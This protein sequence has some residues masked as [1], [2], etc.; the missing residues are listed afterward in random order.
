[1]NAANANL[2]STLTRRGLLRRTATGLLAAATL[3]LFGLATGCGGGGND[4]ATTRIVAGPT[5]AVDGGVTSSW[6]K[7]DASNQVIEAGLTLPLAAI[8]TPSE[9][10]HRSATRHAGTRHETGPAGS[11]LTLDF[12]EVVQQTA[13]LNHF[14]LHWNPNGHEP[15]RYAAPHFDFHFYGVPMTEVAQVTA[16]DPVAPDPSRVPAGY[17]YAGREACV[18]QMGVHAVD[19]AEFAPD[20]APFR[21]SMILGY[22][23]GKMTFVEPMITRAALLEKQPI[24]MTIPRPAVLGRVTR[25]PTHVSITFDSG[26]NAYRCVFTDFVAVTQ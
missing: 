1:M 7:L 25:Y 10:T 24:E 2:S 20:A 23:N 5:K 17:F 8:E 3:P 16:P 4:S 21:A 12:P 15:E 26:L 6:A 19:T 13:Y 18:P 11:F 22:Y 14:E 9:S